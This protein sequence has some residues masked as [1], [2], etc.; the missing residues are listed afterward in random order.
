MAKRLRMPLGTKA[1]I[2]FAGSQ[3]KGELVEVKE[4]KYGT[5]E[6]VYYMFKGENNTL[7]PISE[8]KD[9]EKL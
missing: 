5:V 1:K 2:K 8:P 3:F 4:V 9:I 6:K 7:Y